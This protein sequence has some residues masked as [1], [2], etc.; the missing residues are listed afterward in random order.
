MLKKLYPLAIICP[1]NNEAYSSCGGS[2]LAT[3]DTIAWNVCT[4]TGVT[5]LTVLL[6]LITGF[7]VARK[8]SSPDR[9]WSKGSKSRGMPHLGRTW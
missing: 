3:A 4:W 7:I 6:L 2:F 9:M 5:M 8:C 1:C